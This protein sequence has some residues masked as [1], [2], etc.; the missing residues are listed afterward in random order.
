MDDETAPDWD[1]PLTRLILLLEIAD[2][3][4]WLREMKPPTRRAA[5][6]AG[7]AL[8]GPRQRPRVQHMEG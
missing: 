1:H 8:Q 4:D 5:R 7:S 6:A 3:P 2:G